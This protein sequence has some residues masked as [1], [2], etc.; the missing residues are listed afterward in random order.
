M[1]DHVPLAEFDYAGFSQ[2]LKEA[3][4]PE[5]ITAF[6]E[7]VGVPQATVS[8]YLKGDGTAPRLDIVAQLARG[9][10]VT[11]DWLAYGVGDGPDASAGFVKVPRY[12]ATLA[13]GAGSWNEGKRQLDFIPF[14]AEFFRKRLNRSSGAGFAVLENK[15]DSMEPTI[16]DGA[17]LLIDENDRR[18]IDGIFGFVLDGEARLKR[19]RRTMAGVMIVSDNPAYPPEEVTGSRMDD[20]HIIGRLRWFG[21]EVR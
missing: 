17:L 20:I 19:F 3:I 13:A 7:R 6:A 21:Q 1:V 2:R 14:T 15:G 12:D 16:S 8:K 9:A 10:T 4:F 18:L 11:L 5:K